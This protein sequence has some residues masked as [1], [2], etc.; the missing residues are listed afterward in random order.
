M[1]R[2]ILLILLSLCGPLVYAQG[3]RSAWKT[4][5]FGKVSAMPDRTYTKEEPSDAL[6]NGIPLSK[7]VQSSRYALIIGNEG[8]A[9]KGLGLSDVQFA[10]R[11][12]RAFRVYAEKYFGIPESNVF[13]AENI[14]AG[15]LSAYT[16][17]LALLL[18]ES[19]GNAEVFLYY[20]GHGIVKESDGVFHLVPVD[21][22][23][24]MLEG[25]SSFLR[26]A[27]RLSD[28]GRV[29]VVA[30]TDAC[31]SGQDRKG[32]QALAVRGIRY[33]P[34]KGAFPP[35]VVQFAASRSNQ[36]AYAFNERG[37]GLFTYQLLDRLR[38]S[39]GSETWEE[40]CREVSMSTREQAVRLH[41]REQ[42]PVLNGHPSTLEQF[43]RTNPLSTK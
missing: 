13:Y 12:A 29:R 10:L 4:V 25:G 6:L 15:L 27:E 33:V 23:P 22:D 3:V 42:D 41:Y 19:D 38:R 32:E 1:N 36:T 31:Y 11:D 20:A 37:H 43:K 16:G 28:G 9:N 39:K 5:S 30:F 26:I 40:V 2:I 7:K 14:T 24:E 35:G 17:R 34:V 8:Y 21:A 18:R